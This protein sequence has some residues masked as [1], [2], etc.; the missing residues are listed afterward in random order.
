MMIY[1]CTRRIEYSAYML[2]YN[3]EDTLYYRVEK[4][5]TKNISYTKCVTIN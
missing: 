5:K 4:S 2:F 3:D 1:L